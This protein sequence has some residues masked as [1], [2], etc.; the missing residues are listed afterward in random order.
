MW[1]A[2]R[3]VTGISAMVLAGA[4]VDQYHR[5]E[6]VFE[7]LAGFVVA[8]VGWAFAEFKSDVATDAV[9][10]LHPHDVQL[11]IKL[12]TRL[13]GNMKRFFRTHSFGESFLYAKLDPIRDLADWEG[14]EKDFENSEL[15]NLAAE[16]VRL[17][18]ELI[19]SIFERAKP[20]AHRDDY[21]SIVPDD[22]RA[23]D[24]HSKETSSRVGQIDL[25]A[26]QLADAGD[27]FERAFRRL[28]PESYSAQPR[29]ATVSAEG[30]RIV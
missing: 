28:S 13:D 25:L 6:S 26:D 23:S 18:R 2:G 29:T 10:V 22:E 5:G 21:W 19:N 16:V 7:P 4:I 20:L 30:P 14:P 27:Q 12:K 17:S 3:I 15:D 11:G 8:F 1:R 9:N 24:W